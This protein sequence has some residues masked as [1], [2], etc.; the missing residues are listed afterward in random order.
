MV[1]GPR[2]LSDLEYLQQVESLASAVC[3]AALDE[4]W[5]YAPGAGPRTPLQQ[6]MDDLA[7]DLRHVHFEGDGCL[8][9]SGEDTFQEP[10][11]S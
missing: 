4:G 10:N 11:G 1:D 8:D 7:N 3:A 2:R 5:L 9:S 6:A